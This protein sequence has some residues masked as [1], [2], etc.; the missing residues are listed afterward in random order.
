MGFKAAYLYT[1]CNF[2]AAMAVDAESGTNAPE[3][4]RVRVAA[5]GPTDG[6]GRR[7]IT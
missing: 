4:L 7:D 6:E 2:L 5:Y 3:D 1:L